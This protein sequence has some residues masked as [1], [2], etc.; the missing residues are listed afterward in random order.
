LSSS[1]VRSISGINCRLISYYL[2]LFS[3]YLPL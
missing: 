1:N 2:F 3:H